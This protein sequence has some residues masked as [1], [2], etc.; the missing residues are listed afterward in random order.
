[1]NVSPGESKPGSPGSE[2]ASDGRLPAD[3]VL[4]EL[5]GWAA[6]DRLRMFTAWHR[7]A[8]SLVHL[9]VLALLEAKGP[10]PMSAVAEAMDVSQASATGI[11]DRMEERGLV[12]RQRAE[13][14]RR[15]VSIH[16]TEAGTSVSREI[17]EQRRERLRRIL[18]ELSPEEVEGFLKGVRAIRGARERLVA[19]LGEEHAP[20]GDHDA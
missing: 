4:D 10:L 12:E 19:A 16:L 18:S 11:I 13:G 9:S 17:I 3:A 15:V 6:R 2:T 14:D 7:G 5:T 1:L 20:P 8:L